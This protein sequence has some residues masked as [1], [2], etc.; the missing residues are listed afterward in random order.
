MSEKGKIRY[1]FTSSHTNQGFYTFIPTL[2]GGMK[3]VY[4]LKG[5]PGVGKS[6][7]IRSLGQELYQRGYEVDF[8]LSA[9]DPMNPEGLYI[10]QLESA[11]VNG[12]LPVAI[13]PKYPGLSGSI[14]NLSEYLDEGAI[15][16]HGP[17][18]IDLVNEVEKRSLQ[19]GI[20]LQE[21]SAL[22][23]GMGSGN[24]GRID[25]SKLNRL[26]EDLEEEILKTRMGG[27]H[28]FA[29]SFTS[30]GIINYLEEISSSCK[31]R[32]LLKGGGGAGKVINE[33]AIRAK[34]RGHSLEYYHCGISPDQLIMLIISNLQVA[35]IDA[36]DT[37]LLLRPGDRM[38]DL[39]QCMNDGG[40]FRERLEYSAGQ[41]QY[42]SLLLQA[43]AELEA[44]QKSRKN[45]KRLY[46]GAM[47]FEVLEEKRHELFQALMELAE[48]MK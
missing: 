18:I 47:N 34:G 38:I 23:E 41:R 13:D 4:V 43:Q 1:V 5:A 39:D 32:Y 31:V 15:N 27:R 2:L 22:R 11:V 16:Q 35:I 12:N 17:Q 45:L 20:I 6:S 10:S 29:T 8:W 33:I 14:I 28:Y 30:E 19:A 7:L 21:A 26:I 42:E 3:K 24:C 9:E 48:S 36:G 40:E 44:A 46:S 25:K 37:E